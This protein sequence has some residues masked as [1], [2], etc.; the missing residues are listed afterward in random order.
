MM[1]N[2]DGQV[3]ENPSNPFKRTRSTDTEKGD[4]RRQVEAA[5]VD[6]EASSAK[7]FEIGSDMAEPIEEG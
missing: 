5:S 2:L 6:A 3:L 7:Y 1:F 4:N